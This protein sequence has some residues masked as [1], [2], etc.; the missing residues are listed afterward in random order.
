[1]DHGSHTKLSLLEWQLLALQAQKS[2][3]P[4]RPN[5][6][7][8]RTYPAQLQQN[9][10]RS[11]VVVSLN[12]TNRVCG[13]EGRVLLMSYRKVALKQLPPQPGRDTAEA[14]YWKKFKVCFCQLLPLFA[15]TLLTSTVVPSVTETTCWRNTCGFFSYCTL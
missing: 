14:K 6:H 15:F 7:S 1:M 11:Q 4:V 12:C 8:V 2:L 3:A 9:S 10:P 13:K 5:D